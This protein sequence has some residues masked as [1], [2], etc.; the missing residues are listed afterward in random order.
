MKY[1]KVRIIEY[2]D[3]QAY[4]DLQAAAAELNE[5]TAQHDAAA[6]NAAA[7]DKLAK[8]SGLPADIEIAAAEDGKARALA[9]ALA[10][11]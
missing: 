4:A 9:S 1:I 7:I 8:A 6:R 2:R 10:G 3:N 11:R 5:L